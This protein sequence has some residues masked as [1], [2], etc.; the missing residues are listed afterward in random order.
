MNALRKTGLVFLA[1]CVNFSELLKPQTSGSRYQVPARF[2]WHSAKNVLDIQPLLTWLQVG[3]ANILYLLIE[4]ATH[5]F[6]L[7]NL[8]F[9][10]DECAIIRYLFSAAFATVP[11]SSTYSSKISSCFFFSSDNSLF[12]FG[13]PQCPVIGS[14][15]DAGT[16]RGGRHPPL[17]IERS[18]LPVLPFPRRLPL[19]CRSP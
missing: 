11:P 1:Q 12:L 17:I 18:T 8:P 3:T 10:L 2:I 5:N 7:R 6:L 14:F 13:Y 4:T 9:L 15:D 16:S 19:L